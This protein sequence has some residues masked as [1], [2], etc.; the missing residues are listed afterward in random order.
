[1]EVDVAPGSIRNFQLFR[2]TSLEGGLRWLPEFKWLLDWN[3][4]SFAAGV[5]PEY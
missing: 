5:G 1:M 4:S 3:C 2:A